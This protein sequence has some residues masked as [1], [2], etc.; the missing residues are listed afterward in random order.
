MERA[1]D[2]LLLQGSACRCVLATLFLLPS[3][4][5]SPLNSPCVPSNIKSST[6]SLFSFFSWL[7]CKRTAMDLTKLMFVFTSS[8]RAAFPS[9]ICRLSADSSTPKA[10]AHSEKAMGR[11]R[12]DSSSALTALQVSQDLTQRASS[13]CCFG[14][15]G[16]DGK[17]RE[18]MRIF[19]T[20]K[21]WEPVSA[22]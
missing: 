8:S 9:A 4:P 20:G 11:P 17:E 21:A 13:N 19:G 2:C 16:G 10:R 22:R 5:P 3:S 15:A 12:V 6:L 1:S 7:W 14:G 18:R